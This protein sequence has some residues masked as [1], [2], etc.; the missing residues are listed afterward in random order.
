MKPTPIILID[1]STKADVAA[2][3]LHEVELERL[4][5]TG[6]KWFEIRKEHAAKLATE[7]RPVPQHYHWDWAR[8]AGKTALLAYRCLAV[9]C[10]G[11]IQGLMLLNLTT[12][13]ARLDPD[14]AK[15]LVYVDYVETAPWNAREF[16]NQPQYKSVG[17]ILLEAAVRASLNESFGGR[18]G[19]HSLPQADGFY[20]G[21]GMTLLGTEHRNGPLNYFEFTR[22][23]AAKFIS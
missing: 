15:P 22:D 6:D 16:T 17:S 9:E 7:G 23:A 3:L 14:H 8:K 5:E 10:K 12:H 1:G 18:V 4:E 13:Q 21:C 11:E 19:L 20:A 2:L